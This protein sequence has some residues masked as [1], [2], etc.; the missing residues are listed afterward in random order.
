[1]KT[2][3]LGLLS[4]LATGSASA[5]EVHLAARPRPVPGAYIVVLRP[6]ARS[7]LLA[8]PASSTAAEL[9]KRHGG[10]VTFV[11]EHALRGFAVRMG[12]AAARVLA[13]DPR[14][15]YVEPDGEMTASATQ[16][17]ATWGL[18]RIDQRSLPLSDTYTYDFDGNGVNVYVIDTGIQKTHVDFGGRALHAFTAIDDGRGSDDCAGHGTHVAGTAGGATWGVAKRATLWAVRVLNCAGNGTTSGVIAGVDWVTAN[19]VKPAVANMSLGGAASAALDDAVRASIAAGVTYVVAA[20]NN[21]RSACRHSPARVG[22]AITAGATTM[23]DVRS[24]FSNYGI[25]VDLFAP[26]SAITSAWFDSDTATRTINGTSMA[27]PHVAGAAALLLHADPE[28]TPAE[29]ALALEAAA[30]VDTVAD[31]GYGSPNRLLFTRAADQPPPPPPGPPCTGCEHYAG[32][33]AE[34]ERTFEPGGVRY[35]AAAGT[36]QGWLRGPAGTDFDLFLQRWNGLWWA[37]VA[38]QTGAGSEHAISHAD[39]AGYYRWRIRARTGGGAYDF[40]LVRP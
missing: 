2:S 4:L 18:D 26:G 5:A 32:T 13:A 25:C 15:L 16:T 35:Y 7:T 30:T 17:G 21:G 6:E 22:E 10:T 1:L 9:A 34:G 19:H 38:R 24:S 29:V 8:R 11:Y 3:L 20:G 37:N 12:A 23:G 31:A 27:S 36:H 40:W 14:V 39:R 28:A 33:I